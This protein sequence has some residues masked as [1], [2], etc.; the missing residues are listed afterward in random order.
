MNSALSKLGKMVSVWEGSAPF[1]LVIFKEKQADELQSLFKETVSI[2]RVEKSASEFSDRLALLR[3][4]EQ[5]YVFSRDHSGCFL[6][7]INGFSCRVH[8][9]EDGGLAY[10]T[11]SPGIIYRVSDVLA[12]AGLNIATMH[13][14]RE[15]R[16][17]RAL[18]L[19]TTDGKPPA[20]VFD[21]IRALGAIE[22]VVPLQGEGLS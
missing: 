15:Q 3:T 7:S 9:G 10:H 17:K 2:E 4:G 18:L 1:T 12:A 21:Q 13:L 5:E 11:D 22:Q 6:S 14:S 16:G 20:N 8:A 19:F